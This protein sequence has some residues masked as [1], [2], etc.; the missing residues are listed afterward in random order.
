MKQIKKEHREDN[1]AIFSSWDFIETDLRFQEK[2]KHWQ[3]IC[4]PRLS[5]AAGPLRSQA[6]A[7][8]INSRNWVYNFLRQTSA[9]KMSFYKWQT[10]HSWVMLGES[11]GHSHIISRISSLC[12]ARG[13]LSK[14]EYNA[15]PESKTSPTITVSLSVLSFKNDCIKWPVKASQP[16]HDP[17]TKRQ[18]TLHLQLIVTEGFKP[19]LVAE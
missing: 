5:S 13:T 8:A 19:G 14:N 16:H 12:Q 6:L 9:S 3:S 7:T 15:E 10:I 17:S 2:K 1:W 11:T 4:L 18:Q